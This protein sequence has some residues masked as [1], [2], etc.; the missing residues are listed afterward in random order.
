VK[1]HII[2]LCGGADDPTNLQ[3]QTVADAKAK[4]KWE[5]RG[6]GEG[7][8]EGRSRATYDEPGGIVIFGGSRAGGQAQPA[9]SGGGT[10]PRPATHPGGATYNQSDGIVITGGGRA[11]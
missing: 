6:C 4:D 2:P 5:R 9:D 7:S 11:R 8:F 1:D 10:G 3:W